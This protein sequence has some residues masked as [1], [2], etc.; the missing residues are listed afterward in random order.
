MQC[1]AVCCSVLHCA[2]VCYYFCNVTHSY[3]TY[4]FLRVMHYMSVAFASVCVGCLRIQ[5]VYVCVC[6]CVF[7]CVCVHVLQ[8][9]VVWCIYQHLHADHLRAREFEMRF[10]C[11]YVLLQ[12][13]TTTDCHTVTRCHTLPHTFNILL[14]TATHCN[15]LPHATTC[16]YALQ[17]FVRDVT[18]TATHYQTMP[19]TATHCNTL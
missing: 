15:I 8:C 6:M 3:V 11:M 14:H 19:H 17:Q 10:V 13:H 16:C 2:T 9:V 4:W 18:H 5:C 1:V 12:Q 7:V